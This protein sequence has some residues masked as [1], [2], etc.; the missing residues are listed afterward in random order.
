MLLHEY[1]KCKKMGLLIPL[2]DVTSSQSL[3]ELTLL[4]KERETWNIEGLEKFFVGKEFSITELKLDSCTKVTDLNL[5]IE[6]HLT[7]IRHNNG[8]PTYKQYY[9]RLNN[10]KC[11]LRDEA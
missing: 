1:V 8:N 4:I 2:E 11:K 6:S 7:I 9:N 3:P 10:L 5:F